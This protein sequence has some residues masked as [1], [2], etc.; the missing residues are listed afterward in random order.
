MWSTNI[1]LMR[2][3][4]SFE[5]SEKY[6]S[7]KQKSFLIMFAHVSSWL[8]SRNGDTPLSRTYRM[9]PTLLLEPKQ[10]KQLNIHAATP[11]TPSTPPKPVL[12]GLSRKVKL[13]G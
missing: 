13:K 10:R 1:T 2:S 7:G 4:A 9:T 6:S 8:S 12:M 11:F 5:I 3:I